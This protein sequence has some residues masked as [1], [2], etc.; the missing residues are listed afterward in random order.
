MDLKDYLGKFAW[1]FI[2]GIVL[3]ISYWFAGFMTADMASLSYSIEKRSV[4]G[5]S[6]F[7]MQIYNNEDDIAIDEVVINNLP[8]NHLLS[9]ISEGA[10]NTK[11]KQWSGTIKSGGA[12]ELLI[13][14]DKPL[15]SDK[16][17]ISDILKARYQ[18]RDSESGRLIWK[19]IEISEQG[20]ISWN[21]GTAYIVW[22]AA[23]IVLILLLGVVIFK[24]FLTNGSEESQPQA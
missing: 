10:A 3:V 5:L 11:F 7:Y 16:S 6:S 12:V 2:P 24:F 21:K 13:I 8:S 22:Y 20:M 9:A 19:D 14:S 4:N 18:V 17:A 15:P 23:P 1:G